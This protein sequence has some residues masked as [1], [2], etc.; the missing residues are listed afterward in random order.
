VVS[1]ALALAL[2]EA[3]LRWEPAPGDRFVLPH[4]QMDEDVFVLSDMTVEVHRFP[5]G[6]VIGFNGT[7]EW[8]LDS[9]EQTEALWLPAEEQLRRLLAGLF[10]RLEAISN[11]AGERRFAVT[12][13]VGEDERTFTAVEPAEAYGTALLEVLTE[14]GQPVAG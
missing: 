8:A 3:G 2:R 13:R 14:L 12:I 9:V 6:S 7:T 11:G 4:R 10:V 5:T 1:V